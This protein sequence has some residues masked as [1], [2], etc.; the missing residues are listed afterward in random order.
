MLTV[1]KQI[2]GLIYLLVLV[3]IKRTVSKHHLKR[4]VYLTVLYLLAT[5]VIVPPLASIYRREPVIAN[6]AIQAHYFFYKLMNKTT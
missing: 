1:V 3:L 2:G 6:E 5:C 4:M